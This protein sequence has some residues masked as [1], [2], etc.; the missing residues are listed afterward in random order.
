M[1]EKMEGNEENVQTYQY[2]IPHVLHG[3]FTIILI[4]LNILVISF[5]L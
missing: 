3:K 1:N 4:L 5:K 2:D